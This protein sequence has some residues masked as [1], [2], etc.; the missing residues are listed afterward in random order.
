MTAPVARTQEVVLEIANEPG[1]LG[2]L[3]QLLGKEEIEVLGFAAVARGDTGTLH[4]ITDDHRRAEEVLQE[5]GYVPTNREALLVTLPD[6]PGA[7]GRLA[8]KLGTQGVNIDAAFVVGH[9]ASGRMR[10]AFSVDDVD[11]GADVAERFADG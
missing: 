5:S 9:V 4:M 10:C 11:R 7:L 6:Q 1:T 8:N 2:R 3:S